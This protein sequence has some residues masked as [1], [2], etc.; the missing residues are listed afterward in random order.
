M[1]N[2]YRRVRMQRDKPTG[3]SKEVF[4]S[5][6]LLRTNDDR[7]IG[8]VCGGLG[9]YLKIDAVLVRLGFVLLTIYGGVGPV[10]YLL[11]LILMPLDSDYSEER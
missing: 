2:T 4:M 5:G 3:R 11:L 1:D 7:M 10:L 6:R 9:R 8:G